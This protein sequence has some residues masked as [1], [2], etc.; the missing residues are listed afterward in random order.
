MPDTS[1][2][3]GHVDI[4]ETTVLQVYDWSAHRDTGAL[5]GTFV[6]RDDAITFARKWAE[7]HGRAITEAQLLPLP[8]AV[9]GGHGK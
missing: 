4:Y 3:N 1:T 6:N 7:D 2:L 5:V 8:K 9:D